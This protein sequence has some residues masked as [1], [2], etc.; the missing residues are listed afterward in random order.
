MSRVI[1]AIFCNADDLY[2]RRNRLVQIHAACPTNRQ[3][4]AQETPTPIAT[5]TPIPV[6]E[7]RS[8]W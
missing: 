1:T 4:N 5:P 6:A 8:D 3:C 7:P 2:M